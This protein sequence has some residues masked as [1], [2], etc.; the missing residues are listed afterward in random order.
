MYISPGTGLQCHGM[1]IKSEG[2]RGI[3]NTYTF[4]WILTATFE[5]ATGADYLPWMI[6]HIPNE[7]EYS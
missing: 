4:C 3:N 5:I 2:W 1:E 6:A 7:G